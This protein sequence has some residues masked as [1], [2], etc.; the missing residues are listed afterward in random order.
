MKNNIFKKAF[1]L[2]LAAA[3]LFTLAACGGGTDEASD[4]GSDKL[5]VAIVQPMS[6]SSLDQIRD[7][8][9][10]EL[11]D[12]ASIELRFENANGDNSALT[13]IM[14]NLRNDDIDILVPW[15]TESAQVVTEVLRA[16][17]I[18]VGHVPDTYLNLQQ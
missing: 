12:N 10:A 13:T 4:S 18:V 17:T 14:Q 16:D 7:T 6:H 1:T 9:A 3:S 8:I 15:A 11:E 5:T 2:G